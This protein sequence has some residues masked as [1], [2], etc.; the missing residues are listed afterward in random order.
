MSKIIPMSKALRQEE[1]Q[2]EISISCQHC[3]RDDEFSHDSVI[4]SWEYIG[5][6]CPECQCEYFN[7]TQQ[8]IRIDSVLYE[9]KPDFIDVTG[10]GSYLASP[11]AFEDC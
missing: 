2:T 8:L 10:D 5:Y 1:P 7:V 11:D 3:G 9:V 6:Q 4:E